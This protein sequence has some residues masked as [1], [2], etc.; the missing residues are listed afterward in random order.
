MTGRD[1]FSL[2]ETVAQ[3]LL[4]TVGDS[5]VYIFTHWLVPYNSVDFLNVTRNHTE[6]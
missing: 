5:L 1:I 4:K 2:R 6:K 3:M